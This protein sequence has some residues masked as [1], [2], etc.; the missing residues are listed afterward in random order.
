MPLVATLVGRPICLAHSTVKK[1]IVFETLT[2]RCGT[3][4]SGPVSRDSCERRES[5]YVR[6]RVGQPGQVGLL[7]QWITNL[8]PPH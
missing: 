1:V 5:E 8:T 4:V 7:I 6:S 2:P 3:P